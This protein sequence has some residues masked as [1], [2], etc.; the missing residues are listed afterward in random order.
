METYVKLPSAWEWAELSQLCA[1]L[2]GDRGKNYPSKDMLSE[3]GF[4]FVNAGHIQNNGIAM[5][6]MN[7]IDDRVFGLL[8][9]GKFK[10][11]DILFCIRGSLGKVALNTNIEIGAIA[12]SLIIVRPHREIDAKYIQ[13]YLQ[14]P[15]STNM[16]RRFDNGTAQ[17]NL[18]GKD[19]GRFEVPVP[20][21]REQLRIVTKIE[22]LLSE[23]DNG[24]E[25]LETARK[26]FQA[27]RSAL[28]KGAFEGKLTAN[29]REERKGQLETGEQFMRRIE[30][31]NEDSP[32]FQPGTTDTLTDDEYDDLPTLPVGWV[33]GRLG[34]FIEGIEAGKSFKCEEREPDDGEIGV[35]KVSAVTWGEYN[36]KESKTCVDPEKVN[37][38]Y[39]IREGDFL[40]SR[41]NTIE[42]IGACVIVRDT[43]KNIML[44]DK[45][46]RIAFPSGEKEYFLQYLRSHIGRN[47]IMKRS[48]GN[49]E[50]MRNIGQDRIRSIVVP[51]CSQKEM[52]AIQELLSKHFAR[53]EA[54]DAVIVDEL[55]RSEALR[56]SILKMAFSGKLVAQDATDEAASVLLGRIKFETTTPGKDK[57]KADRRAAA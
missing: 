32:R 45:T 19:F 8:R 36:E 9:A 38:K 54:L 55:A 22:E 47:E 50:S 33:Y 48:T 20:P 30:N 44:S 41:A 15:L 31:D 13:Y 27:Y 6:D 57:R 23:L 51:V 7:F 39:F 49:Q 17:P 43:T 34:M 56:R 52:N 24:V 12:S 53:I 10:V 28:L 16:I 4:P 14:S 3:Q 40:F 37:P 11:G 2:N 26:Q 46:L 21:Y 18:S 25:C 5:E 1:L 35:A 42:L 29:W